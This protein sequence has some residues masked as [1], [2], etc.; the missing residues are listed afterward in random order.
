MINNIFPQVETVKYVNP[1]RYYIPT[2][3]LFLNTVTLFKLEMHSSH[4]LIFLRGR[5]VPSFSLTMN[6][7]NMRPRYHHNS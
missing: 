1:T 4:S 7:I 5:R 6:L 3:T 2:S